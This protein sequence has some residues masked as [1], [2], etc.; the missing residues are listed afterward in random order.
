MTELLNPRTAMIFPG[1]GPVPFADMARFMHFNPVARRMF[2][3][4][5]EIVGYPIADR[6]RDDEDDYSEAAQVAFLVS[7]LALAEW[8]RQR[9]GVDADVCVGPSFGQKAAAAYVGTLSFA[10]AVTMT[11]GLARVTDAYFREAH[12][13]IVTHSFVRIP[14]ESLRS[15]LAELSADGHWHEMSCVVDHDFTML[16]LTEDR[17][18][19]LRERIRA[20]GG[21]SLYTMRPPMHTS[22]FGEL[23]ERADNEVLS[24][25]TFADPIVPLISDQDGSVL[26]TGEQV[27][28]MILDGFTTTVRWTDAVATLLGLDVRKVCVAGQDAMFGRVAVTTDNFEVKAVNPRSAL[29]PRRR[30]QRESTLV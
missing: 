25:L 14:Q 21:M 11:A 29:R 23:R 3:E 16:S 7:C 2:E 8:A 18:P 27:R 30:E 19:W 24:K 28:T 13:D 10:D 1:M 17:I 20:L 22:L 6:Y 12:T 9:E 5:D 26:S 4:A 15:L